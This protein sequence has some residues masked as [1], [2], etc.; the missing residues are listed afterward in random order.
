MLSEPNITTAGKIP[1]QAIDVEKSVLASMLMDN[2]TIGYAVEII[3]EDC[4]Y[5]EDHKQIYLAIIALFQKN[6]PAD[7]ITVVEELKKR[8]KLKQAGEE[9]YIAE[10]LETASTSANIEYYSKILLEKSTLRRLISA[11]HEISSKCFEATDEA[12]DLLDNAESKIFAISESRIRQGFVRIDQILKS[13][14]EDI[15]KYSSGNINGVPSGFDD[16]DSLTNGFQPG[17][18]IIVAARPGVGKTSF[19]LSIMLNASL[20]YKKSVALFSL[21]MS[22]EELTQR[23]LC[24]QARVNSHALRKG[25]LP[26]R[27]YPKLAMAAE[28]LSNAPIFIDDSA[29]LNVLELRA[30]ARRLQR[31][32]NIDIIFVDYLQLMHGASSNSENRQQEIAIISRSLKGLA[33]ELGIPI[34]ALSQLSRNVENRGKD[35]KPQLSDLRESG[36]IEQDADM[37]LFIHRNFKEDM[38]SNEVEIII[39]KQRNGPTDPP[40]KLTFA[41]SYTRFENLSRRDDSGAGF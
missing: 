5:R 11:S 13:T 37:V 22:K 23:L 19:A 7:L 36:A 34:V 32:N 27:D 30:K 35:A 40:V 8:K 25:H 12:S 3:N 26:K 24:S 1:P 4:F 6:H 10:L 16:L 29:A 33:K 41:S 31:Q 28:P 38:E 21:E 20:D 9:M 39:G 15:D 2:E 18:L 17:N 14:F